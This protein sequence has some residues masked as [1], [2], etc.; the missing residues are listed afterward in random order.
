M[1]VWRKADAEFGLAAHMGS[2]DPD[3][4]AASVIRTYG[5]ARAGEG[6][7]EERD[8]IVAWLDGHEP[9][10]AFAIANGEHLGE[11]VGKT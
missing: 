2:A 10:L 3:E 4:Y 9:G 6:A 1:E 7:A 11:G 8:Q 5:D